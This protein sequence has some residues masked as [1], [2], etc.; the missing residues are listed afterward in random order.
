MGFGRRSDPCG[1][2]RESVVYGRVW[3]PLCEPPASRNELTASSMAIPSS[4][5]YMLGYEELLTRISPYFTG[6]TDPRLNTSSLNRSVHTGANSSFTLAPLVAGSVARTFS[7]TVISPIEMFRTRLQALPAYNKPSPS[8]ASTAKDMVTLV[9]RQGLHVLWRGLGPTLWRD[10]PF[11]GLYWA[12]FEILKSRLSSPNTS[13]LVAS[14]FSGAIS[15]TISALLTQPFDV[16]KTRRQVFTSSKDPAAIAMKQYTST[17]PLAMHVIRTEGWGAL[18]TGL[19]A[20]CGKVAPACGLMIA[21]YEGV[22]RFLGGRN[23]D[24]MELAEQLE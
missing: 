15:G 3:G 20:R 22:G 8:Y 21:C 16:L 1:E 9:Q 11:S 14:F 10:V 13:P 18:F 12:G 24:A 6:S 19:T 4:A 23:E 7:A 5:M 2:R 17:V